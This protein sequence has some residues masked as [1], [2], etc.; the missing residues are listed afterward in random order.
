M[1]LKDPDY[2]QPYSMTGQGVTI[3]SNRVSYVYNLTGPSLTLDTACSSSIY[4]AHM[5]CRA[6]ASGEVDGAVVGGTNLIQAVEIHLGTD[7]MGVLSPTS[8][9]HTFDAAA[10]GYGRG[11]GI[12]AIYLKRLNDAIRDGDPIRGII[13]GTAANANG[14]TSGIT[15]P[16]AKGQATVIRQAYN[17][18]GI[19]NLD[20]TSYFETHVSAPT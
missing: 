5:A 19:T 4:A 3:L 12:G 8:T 20:E 14:K 9:C 7:K 2:P 1:N 10:D 18:A 13:R 6:L 16:S 11:E 15:Q 17:F